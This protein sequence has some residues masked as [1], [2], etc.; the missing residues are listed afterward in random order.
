MMKIRRRQVR[1]TKVLVQ[2]HNAQKQEAQAPRQN[3]AGDWDPDFRLFDTEFG[4]HLFLVDGSRVYSVPEELVDA[5]HVAQGTKAKILQAYGL[6][7]ANYID[8]EVLRDPPLRAIS[9]AIAQS[10]NLG[11]VYCYAQQGSF[12]GEAK[13]MVRRAA[14]GAIDLL[15]PEAAA[16]DL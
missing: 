9:L 4:H 3:M 12:G 13:A 8:D 11:C 6:T 1:G 5:L 14:L 16:G 10:C 15:F 2:I 7:T